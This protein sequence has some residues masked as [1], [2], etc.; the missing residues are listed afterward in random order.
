MFFPV[1][2]A[3]YDAIAGDGYVE[4]HWVTSF[5]DSIDRFEID[6][7][8]E[9]IASVEAA[10]SDSGHAYVWIDSSVVNTFH[11][12][13]AL[14][15][16]MLSG[17]RIELATVAAI[18]R[19][20]WPGEL[21][22]FGSLL[23]GHT[24]H[25]YWETY[26]ESPELNRFEIDRDGETVLS[27][28]AGYPNGHWYQWPDSNLTIGVEYTYLLSAVDDTERRYGLSTLVLTLQGPVAV[29]ERPDVPVEFEFGNYPNP[30][31][32]TT[33]LRY[34]LPSAAHVTLSIYNIEGRQ[35]ATLVNEVMTAGEHS[36]LWSADAQA[37]GIYFATL[38]SGD[39]TKSVKLVYLK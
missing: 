18:P 7:N 31:N 15:A 17:D 13:Y 37:S 9:L 25:L 19:E 28:P 24:I 32:N 2:L 20:E 35:V 34:E 4:L 14:Y 30:F 39:V 26:S 12:T 22:Y 21:T 33:T 29:N 1:E 11:Y 27:T 36:I 6:R 38:R 16:L 5:E 10:N 23:N 8:G 3:G